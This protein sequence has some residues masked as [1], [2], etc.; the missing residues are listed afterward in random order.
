MPDKK[1]TIEKLGE[2]MFLA[3]MLAAGVFFENH[4]MATE[5]SPE[6]HAFFNI[7]YCQALQLCGYT[8]KEVLAAFRIT[9]EKIEKTQK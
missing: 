9:K 2:E 6:S 5:L 1:L 8:E 4:P 7:G 3:S